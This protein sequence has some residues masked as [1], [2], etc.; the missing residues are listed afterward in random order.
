MFTFFPTNWVCIYIIWFSVPPTTSWQHHVC[1]YLAHMIITMGVTNLQRPDVC[2][3]YMYNRIC[4]TSIWFLTYLVLLW[5]LAALTH[6]FGSHSMMIAYILVLHDIC[7]SVNSESR[8]ASYLSTAVNNHFATRSE[9]I[10]RVLYLLS[11]WVRIWL[12]LQMM[13]LT[14]SSRVPF[15]LCINIITRIL[16]W[17]DRGAPG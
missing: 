7:F 14:L 5:V 6:F 13:L 4:F 12:K 10:F 1:F 8:K 15:S 16:F 17:L 3:V 11:L 2:K 9:C